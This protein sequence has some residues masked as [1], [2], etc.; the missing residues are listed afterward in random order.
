MRSNNRMHSAISL[1]EVSPGEYKEIR[2]AASRH[3]LCLFGSW[4]LPQRTSRAPMAGYAWGS[5][6]LNVEDPDGNV[7]RLGSENKPAEPFGDW[8][9][10]RG[11]HLAPQAR[12]RLGEGRLAAK[13]SFGQETRPAGNLSE[14]PRGSNTSL[15]G[16]VAAQY[17]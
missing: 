1:G 15:S 7:L 8:L 13:R 10:M 2:R 3:E 6:E 11:I 9:D 12:G 16:A 4:L 5:R 14:I 17:N